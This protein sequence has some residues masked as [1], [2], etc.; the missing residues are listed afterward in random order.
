MTQQPPKPEPNL[1]YSVYSLDIGGAVYLID[2]M[3]VSHIAVEPQH[4]VKDDD[5][6]LYTVAI[7]FSGCLQP[8][9]SFTVNLTDELAKKRIDDFTACYVALHH[10][11]VMYE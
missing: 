2:M 7:T 3:E 4:P 8:A 5:P 11:E 10:N 6:V 9:L 1:D